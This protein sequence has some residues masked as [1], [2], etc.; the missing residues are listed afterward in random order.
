LSL[1]PLLCLGAAPL[2]PSLRLRY[3]KHR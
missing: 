3:H 1:V 2:D